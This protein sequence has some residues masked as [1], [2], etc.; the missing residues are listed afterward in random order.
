MAYWLMKSEPSVYSIDDLQRDGCTSWTGVRNYQV[1][2]MFRDEFR[3][4]DLA[5]FYH[6]SCAQPGIVG[7]MNVSA[8]A[9]PDPEQ[10]DR[11][12][13]YFEARASRDKPVWLAVD[14]CFKQ[15]F[16]AVLTLDELRRHVQLAELALLRRGNRL[17]VMPVT[18]AQWRFVLGP[19]K[20]AVK[21]LTGVE[22]DAVTRDFSG[23]SRQESVCGPC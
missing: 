10:F 14:V 16:A 7:L 20:A 19:G 4:G 1:R 22:A 23:D 8:P 15:K 13:E 18:P 3:V 11:R 2:N 6:S 17:S 5:F 9:S 21:I 12:S